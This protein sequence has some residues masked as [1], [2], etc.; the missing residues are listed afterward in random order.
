[1]CKYCEPESEE[2][3]SEMVV[4]FGLLGTAKICTSVGTDSLITE[5]YNID[6]AE[7]KAARINYCPMC[8]RK[9][10]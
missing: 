4:D 7:R 9:L 5:F 3:V 10:G 2:S 6:D 8:G 1:M